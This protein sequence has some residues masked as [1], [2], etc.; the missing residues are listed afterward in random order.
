MV[1]LVIKKFKTLIYHVWV[2]I[3]N[4]KIWYCKSRIFCKNKQNEIKCEIYL[5]HF[6]Q[7]IFIYLFKF[8]FFFNLKR[9]YLILT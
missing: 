3:K 4:W 2:I 6:Y 5:S 1:E 8:K 7:K 9:I